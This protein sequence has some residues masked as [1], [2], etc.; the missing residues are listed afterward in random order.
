MTSR[1]RSARL[2]RLW[3]LV[4]IGEDSS[5]PVSC[6]EGGNLCEISSL[7]SGAVIISALVR[8]QNL[9]DQ[10][11]VKP[12]DN[13]LRRGAP[14][15]EQGGDTASRAGN[16]VAVRVQDPPKAESGSDRHEIVKHRRLFAVPPSPNLVV[17]NLA[18][19]GHQ[20]D[21]TGQIRHKVILTALHALCTRLDRRAITPVMSGQPRTLTDPPHRR[22]AAIQGTIAQ[23]SQADSAGSI[24]VTRSA[25]K[26]QVEAW[27]RAWA[28]IVWRSFPIF[29]AITPWGREPPA[30]PSWH[31]FLPPS[32]RR[33]AMASPA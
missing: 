7:S 19:D 14:Q 32:G 30:V 22:S 16:I 8:S 27:F 31:H 2:R 20:R 6:Q 10:F 33:F 21:V 4:L 28:L 17:R 29:R 13:I 9:A 5:A 18:I 3:L 26:A 1:A 11:I 25:A 12:R 15:E 23:I 24:P